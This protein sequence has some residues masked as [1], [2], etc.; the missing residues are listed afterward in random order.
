MAQLSEAGPTR[1][2]ELA[3]LWRSLQRRFVPQARRLRID[4][5]RSATAAQQAVAARL[6]VSCDV[7]PSAASTVSQFRR[8]CLMTTSQLVVDGYSELPEVPI[9]LIA[10]FLQFLSSGMHGEKP[11]RSPDSIK[12]KVSHLCQAANLNLIPPLEKNMALLRGVMRNMQKVL[13]VAYEPNQAPAL[14]N[15]HLKKILGTAFPGDILWARLLTAHRGLLRGA[16]HVGQAIPLRRVRVKTV[17][18]MLSARIYI[19]CDKTRK[20]DPSAEVVVI[21]EGDVRYRTTQA[22]DVV[23]GAI[24]RHWSVPHMLLCI[25]G[26]E[27]VKPPK[28]RERAF[29]DQ[30]L[31]YGDGMK[32]VPQFNQWL[33]GVARRAGLE[34]ALQARASAHSLR[35]GGAT[36]LIAAG[37]TPAMVMSLGRWK[38][39]CYR[40]YVR[41]KGARTHLELHPTWGRSMRDPDSES[42]GFESEPD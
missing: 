8:Y 23:M 22:P 33:R 25:Y 17:R 29:N 42:D 31:F 4:V 27:L 35:A 28:A 16:E 14:R 11:L 21:P 37:A 36:D 39:L 40:R 19:K 9:P 12:T 24:A 5:G 6:G 32:T 38:S 20:T 3:A 30:W 1:K 18:G 41:A 26:Q 15:K 2:K 10:G 13:A 7:S 34:E